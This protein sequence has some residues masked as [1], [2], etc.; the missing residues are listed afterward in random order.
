MGQVRVR[1]AKRTDRCTLHKHVEMFT[2][3]KARSHTDEW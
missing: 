2:R 1:V 3:P